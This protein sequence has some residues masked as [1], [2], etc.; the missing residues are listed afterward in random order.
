MIDIHLI[1]ASMVA[2]AY[3][4]LALVHKSRYGLHTSPDGEYYFKAGRGESVPVPYSLRP[5]VPMVCGDS[6]TMWYYVTYAH[7]GLLGFF[8]YLLGIYYGLTVAEAITV[9]ACIAV[10]RSFVK[11]QAY[12]PA[13]VDAHAH[14][15]AMMIAVTAMSGNTALAIML[16]IFGGLINEKTPVFAAIYAWSFTPLVGVLATVVHFI[17]AKHDNSRQGIDWMDR[18]YETA[19]N[20]IAARVHDGTWSVYFIAPLGVAWLGIIGNATPAYVALVLSASFVLRAMDYRRLIAW[21]LPLM[22][23]EAVR[24]TPAPFLPMLP[25][26]HQYIVETEC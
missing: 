23:I 3:T 25:L 13:L 17:L 12:Y 6:Y 5:L 18:P 10:S 1:V 11:M 26:I 20:A 22:L 19:I 24:F 7:I 8:S 14:A 4:A 21:G 2:L 15:W 16:A 9:S